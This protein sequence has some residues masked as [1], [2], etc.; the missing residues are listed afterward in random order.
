M[1]KAERGNQRNLENN[2]RKQYEG[3]WTAWIIDIVYIV[4]EWD[5]PKRMYTSPYRDT[6][7]GF[8]VGSETPA[9]DDV[10]TESVGWCVLSWSGNTRFSLINYNRSVPA[11]PPPQ[12]KLSNARNNLHETWY[13]YHGDWVHLCVCIPS[14]I[15]ING[16]VK[17][18]SPLG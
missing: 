15:T 2:E 6:H 18:I 11:Y 5:K 1:E 14:I 13:V 7:L 12:C 9:P 3:K 17:C 16:S 8:P 4:K 10:Y